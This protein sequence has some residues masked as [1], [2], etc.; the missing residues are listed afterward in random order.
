[1][2]LFYR[3]VGEGENYII[4]LHGLLGMS[5]NWVRIAKIFSDMMSAKVII[6]D[7]RNHGISMHHPVFN[8]D[9]L[10]DDVLE[11]YDALNIQQAV[12]LG[13]SMGGKVAMQFALNEPDRVASLIVADIS[14]VQYKTNRH[15]ELIELMYNIDFSKFQNRKQIEI[16]LKDRIHDSQ[17]VWFLLKNVH[18]VSRNTYGW[19][20]HIESLRLNLEEVFRFDQ[21]D[22][23]FT[24]KTLFLKGEL[25]D[26][27]QTEHLPIIKQ[28][29][30]NYEMKTIS[31]A[32]HWLH[33]DNQKEFSDTVIQFLT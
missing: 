29:F 5:D 33:S 16:H 8:Y 31:N 12:L 18:E 22:T 21:S 25:S 7:Q 30:P 15:A 11:L 20:L 23:Q 27:I 10:V 17:L 1:M 32:G 19:K 13:H 2:K 4:I 14:P 26:F 3:E 6:P 28:F 24:K 9:A